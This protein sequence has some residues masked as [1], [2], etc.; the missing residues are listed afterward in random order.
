[1]GV[2]V[3]HQLEAALAD[4]DAVMLLRIQ[5]ERQTATH[6]P[7]IGEYTSMFG[8]N[9]A[10]AKWLKPGAIIMHPGPINRGV[11]IDSELADSDQSVILQQVTNGIVIRMAVLHLCYCAQHRKPDHATITSRSI[12][13]PTLRALQRSGWFDF[14]TYE[15]NTLDSKRSGH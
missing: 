4:A 7:S 3:S 1:M 12:A 5:H 10:R 15:Q 14:F 2:T 13:P 11:E 9:K 8:L 6:F